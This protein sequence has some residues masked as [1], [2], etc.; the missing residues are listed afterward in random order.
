M[1]GEMTMRTISL[2]LHE[3]ISDDL[4]CKRRYTGRGGPTILGVGGTGEEAATAAAA[5]GGIL[6]PRYYRS[7][8]KPRILAAHRVQLRTLLAQ[9]PE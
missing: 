3:R 9:K 6:G 2:D 4:R 1:V 5:H 8:R 7:G